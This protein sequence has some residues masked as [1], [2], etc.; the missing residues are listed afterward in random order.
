MF[1][2]LRSL[3]CVVK[4]CRFKL[5]SCKI[6][7]ICG[8]LPL[9]FTFIIIIGQTCVICVLIYHI[10]FCD[11]S[12]LHYHKFCCQYISYLLL[13]YAYKVSVLKCHQI[14]LSRS[15]MYTYIFFSFGCS[16]VLFLH[17]DLFWHGIPTLRLIN[18]LL[19]PSS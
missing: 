2:F 16:F 11:I 8:G 9:S 17:E 10:I 7:C 12:L 15:F 19:S 3:C 13:Q 6:I 1:L 4:Y 18:V 5:F 14:S